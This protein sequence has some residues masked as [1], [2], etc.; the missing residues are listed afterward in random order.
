MSPQP[1]DELFIGCD[2][3]GVVKEAFRRTPSGNVADI[4]EEVDRV[5]QNREFFT[6]YGKKRGPMTEP[7]QVTADRDAEATDTMLRG[8]VRDISTTWR[9][10]ARARVQANMDRYGLS[11]QEQRMAWAMFSDME[12]KEIAD[13][14]YLSCSTIKNYTWSIGGRI[15]SH[16]R[17]AII[18]KLLDID[19]LG[20]R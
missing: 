8:I 10:E 4:T 16:G 2:E 9:D 18:L 3:R 12:A 7:W 6:V 17:L 14:M 13:R 5:E 15:G 20:E 19:G 1:K 11:P